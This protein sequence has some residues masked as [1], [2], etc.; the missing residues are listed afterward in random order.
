M[1]SWS[2]AGVPVIPSFVTNDI[3]NILALLPI[4]QLHQ[5]S[6]HQLL[7]IKVGV[8]MVLLDFSTF[9]AN[10]SVPSKALEIGYL[11]LVPSSPTDPAVVKGMMSQLAKVT[12]VVGMTV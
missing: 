12:E 8:D 1:Q 2:L 11:P 7:D 6:P 5:I 3:D 10:L 4:W 9:S